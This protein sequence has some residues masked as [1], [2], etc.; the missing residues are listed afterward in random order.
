MFNTSKFDAMNRQIQ[1]DYRFFRHRAKTGVLVAALLLSFCLPRMAKCEYNREDYEEPAGS[2][3]SIFL[4][5]EDNI[6]GVSTG[7]GTW[8]K[9]T[10]IFGNYAISLF[11]NGAEDAWYASVGMTLRIMPHWAFTPFVGGGGSYNYSFSRREENP[12]LYE[13]NTESDLGDSYWGGQAEAGF[14]LWTRE[15]RKMYEISA[16]YIWTSLN[17]EYWLV[18]ISTGIGI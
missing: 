6:Y 18:G 14:R 5:P 3:G 13:E 4:N 17:R 7:E 10:P 1:I 11:S 8:L 16:Q 15:R 2:A 9:G 12:I